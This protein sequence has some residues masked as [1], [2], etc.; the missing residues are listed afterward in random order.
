MR[1]STAIRE[2][3][4]PFDPAGAV[5]DLVRALR[6]YGVREVRG[7]R[8]GG[9]WVAAEFRKQGVWY[10]TAERPKSDLYK[11]LCRW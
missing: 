9:E 11:E 5:A 4:P 2:V 8:F 10:R 1:C 3:R 7:D 6:S